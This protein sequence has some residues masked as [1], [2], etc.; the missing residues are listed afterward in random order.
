MRQGMVY[1]MAVRKKKA[2]KKKAVLVGDGSPRLSFEING[3]TFRF[4][5]DLFRLETHN[6]GLLSEQISRLPA[7]L[8]NVNEALSEAKDQLAR[9]QAVLDMWRALRMAEV[10]DEKGR[11]TDKSKEACVRVEYES[12]WRAS[13]DGI[14]D[15]KKTVGVLYGY[16]DAVQ[17]AI[18]LSQ[19]IAGN[20]RGERDAYNRGRST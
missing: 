19:T 6:I 8:A 20:L 5:A 12:D 15:S 18:S 3:R 2:A 17:S 13:E 16:R 10:F 7:E 1:V 14:N 9:G 11:M 4:P